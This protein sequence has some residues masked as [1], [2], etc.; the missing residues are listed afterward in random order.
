MQKITQTLQPDS[1]SFPLMTNS[2]SYFASGFQKYTCNCLPQL[3][4]ISFHYCSNYC[5]KYRSI[6]VRLFSSSCNFSQLI[7]HSLKWPPQITYPPVD[8]QG[9]LKQHL[10]KGYIWEKNN[11]RFHLFLHNTVVSKSISTV[12]SL[13][14][15]GR[16]GFFGGAAGFHSES[17]LGVT[18]PTSESRF[19]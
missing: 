14:Q 19:M 13:F 8:C 11:C 5:S 16:A 18:S 2:V 9:C 1:S 10:K 3:P 6:I 4:F 15:K 7:T 17:P 12:A